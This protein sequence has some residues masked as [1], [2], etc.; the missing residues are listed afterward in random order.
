MKI[1]GHAN[2]NKLNTVTPGKR[3]ISFRVGKGN[4]IHSL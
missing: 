4:V 1:N 3:A 2:R